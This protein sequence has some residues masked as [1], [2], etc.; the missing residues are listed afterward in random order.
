MWFDIRA[1]DALPCASCRV[2]RFQKFISLASF[3]AFNTFLLCAYRLI[4][5]DSSAPNRLHFSLAKAD[6]ISFFRSGHMVLHRS[7]DYI[8]QG[9]R[10]TQRLPS[11]AI[12]LIGQWIIIGNGTKCGDKK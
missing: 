6:A 10:S 8:Q 12:F 7:S 5:A 9:G 11:V 2:G 4:A 1:L 3:R